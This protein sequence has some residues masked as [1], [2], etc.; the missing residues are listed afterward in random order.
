MKFDE[1]EPSEQFCPKA[2]YATKSKSRSLSVY[3]CSTTTRRVEAGTGGR[4]RGGGCMRG[5]GCVRRGKNKRGKTG[6][7]GDRVTSDALRKCRFY[8]MACDAVPR[9]TDICGNCAL[10]RGEHSRSRSAGQ[11]LDPPRHRASDEELCDD[12]EEKRRE[13]GE[14]GEKV[15]MR[16]RAEPSPLADRGGAGWTIR[17]GCRGM[18]GQ[19]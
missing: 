19:L 17:G 11:C 4:V 18:A 2:S 14:K 13:K 7:T 12:G 6:T 10:A 9:V 16:E 15:K 3:L 5:G 1:N 8:A